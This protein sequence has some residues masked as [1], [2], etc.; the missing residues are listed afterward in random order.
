[1]CCGMRNHKLNMHNNN[2]YVCEKTVKPFLPYSDTFQMLN[3]YQ[4]GHLCLNNWLLI[5]K[6]SDQFNN[7]LK[8]VNLNY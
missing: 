5:F 3:P 6:S 1:M 7:F 8:M 2:E 4:A